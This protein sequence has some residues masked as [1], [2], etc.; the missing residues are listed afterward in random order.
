[1]G[2][3]TP[4]SDTSLHALG[5]FKQQ[6][7]QNA[8]SS[9][10][11]PSTM[12]GGSVNP[13]QPQ[14]PDGFIR[15]PIAA[16]K[17]LR[18]FD[19]CDVRML[20]K[21]HLREK[22]ELFHACS[23]LR[24]ALSRV[25]GQNSDV[26]TIFQAIDNYKSEEDSINT[27]LALSAQEEIERLKEENVAMKARITSEAATSNDADADAD[28]D[29]ASLQSSQALVKQLRMQLEDSK[30]EYEISTAAQMELLK[31]AE[32]ERLKVEQKLEQ[33]EKVAAEAQVQARAATN[34]AHDDSRRMESLQE[35]QNQLDRSRQQIDSLESKVEMLEN[36]QAK[37]T[38]YVAELE[39]AAHERD[40]LWQRLLSAESRLEESRTESMSLG[41]LK[42]MLQAS[43]AR[44]MKAEEELIALTK[45]AAN[46]EAQLAEAKLKVDT[47]NAAAQSAIV[48]LAGMEELV[49]AKV[50]DRWEQV[51]KE[52]LKWPPSALEEIE[53]L[54]A[55]CSALSALQSTANDRVETLEA[56]L[57]ESDSRALIAESRVEEIQRSMRQRE[58]RLEAA[59][60]LASKQVDEFRDALQQVEREN[61]VLTGRLQSIQS[62]S[63]NVSSMMREDSNAIGIAMTPTDVQYLKHVLLKFLSVYAQ[64]RR[65]ECDI[66]LQAMGTV[67]RASASEM[68]QL[69]NAAF[70]GTDVLGWLGL[71]TTS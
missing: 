44:R 57:K 14:N 13:Q 7:A 62:R 54:E 39:E 46:L 59:A 63:K 64:G 49:E 56:Q 51:G 43:D 52:R 1:M 17:K 58:D 41:T 47:S 18:W 4:P 66:L 26:S 34:G 23:L 67:L 2:G 45:F 22:Q 8:S 3:I 21:L 10:F 50:Q 9:S 28:A 36:E 53:V 71:G 12:P 6:L 15:V 27:I 24:E 25:E 70:S 60:L 42:D 35:L 48:K 29:D 33:A 11:F 19:Q 40:S 55:R 5:R 20:I 68:K 65:S 32:E 16:A 61:Q 69:R 38:T 37:T 30:R 31:I